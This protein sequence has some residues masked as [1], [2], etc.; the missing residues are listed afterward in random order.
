MT[1]FSGRPS[2][3][4]ETTTKELPN[5]S[6]TSDAKTILRFMAILQPARD[7]PRPAPA[8]RGAIPA[9]STWSSPFTTGSEPEQ[10]SCVPSEDFFFIG[11][12]QREAAQAVQDQLRVNPRMVAGVQQPVGPHKLVSK[13]HGLRQRRHDVEVDL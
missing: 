9:R 5:A 2:A 10:F 13:P 1:C 11:L 12:R 8:A 6:S 7:S 4:A 3:R